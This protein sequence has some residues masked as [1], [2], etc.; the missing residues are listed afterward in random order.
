VDGGREGW[1]QGDDSGRGQLRQV[2][3]RRRSAQ[4][5]GECVATQPTRLPAPAGRSWRADQPIVEVELT[6][7]PMIG[8]ARTEA[9]VCRS[10]PALRAC[11]AVGK[12]LIGVR[13]RC[14]G[15]GLRRGVATMGRSFFG[16]GDRHHSLSEDGHGDG[17]GGT[18]T[19]RRH[20]P[21]AGD[22]HRFG[23]RVHHPGA[24]C[25]PIRAAGARRTGT[26]GRRR[27]RRCRL[28]RSRTELGDCTGSHHGQRSSG[29]TCL[30][31]RR[32]HS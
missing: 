16:D 17:D 19:R 5:G 11:S 9:E 13:S 32:S 6:T 22:G 2:L 26:L 25:V 10:C 4:Q 23:R 14:R 1:P 28:S 12:P 30:S 29:Q 27:A 31:Q 20:E 18:T 24:L 8:R 3:H 15:A 21:S 7:D